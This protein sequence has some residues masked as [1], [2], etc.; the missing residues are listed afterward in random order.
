MEGTS[1]LGRLIGSPNVPVYELP[2]LS[3]SALKLAQSLTFTVRGT[4]S[5][6]YDKSWKKRSKVL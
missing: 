5:E 6:T 3:R 4:I 1:A 2:L